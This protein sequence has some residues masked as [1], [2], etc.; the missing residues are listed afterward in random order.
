[1]L[2]HGGWDD[3]NFRIKEQGMEAF[4]GQLPKAVEDR[5]ASI[6][7]EANSR[8]EVMTVTWSLDHYIPLIEYAEHG[9]PWILV[10]YERLVLAGEEELERVL[11][12]LDAE[13]TGSIRSQLSVASAYAS[14]DLKTTNKGKQLAKWR[15]RLTDPQIDRILEIVSAFGL[16]FYTRDLEPDYDRLMQFSS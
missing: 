2:S 8:L 16:D 6:F 5:F 1:M 14:N 7:D 15:S 9:H 13:M 4:G 11:S 10:P 12:G 3:E